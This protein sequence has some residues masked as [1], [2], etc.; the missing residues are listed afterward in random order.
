MKHILR[1][2]IA[3]ALLAISIPSLAVSAFAQKYKAEKTTDHGV[4]IVRLTDA[5]AGVEVSM[6]PSFGNLAY[7]MKVHGNNIFFFSAADVSELIK[8]HG[9]GGNPFLAPWAN[10]LGEMDFWANGKKYTFNTTLGNIRSVTPIHGV[11]LNS[12]YWEVT[13]VKADGK[14]AHVTSRLQF[15]KHPDLMEQWPFAHEYEMTY[16][17]AKGVL[18]VRLTVTNL[19]TD[20]MPVAVGFHPCFQIPGILR[21]DI[22]ATN[23]ARK[24]VLTDAR[25][26]ATGEYKPYDLPTPF[27]LKGQALDTGYVDLQRDAQGRAHFT[28]ES[29]GKKVEMTIGPK[30]PTAMVYTPPKA[31]A[32]CLEP[33]AAISNAINLNHEGKYPDLQILAPGAKWTESFWVNSAGI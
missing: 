25:Q 18:E 6:V 16:Q 23:P 32:A 19:S 5:A 14:S 29:G 17:L 21:D 3:I 22:M 33:M 7:E 4:D 1:K 8:G 31:Q 13:E 28:F 24:V 12:P 11:L 10:R 26:V 2:T 27:S 15:W 20:P 30:Y 9:A